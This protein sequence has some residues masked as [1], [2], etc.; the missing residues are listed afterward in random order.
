MAQ[1]GGGGFIF[2]DQVIRFSL[3]SAPVHATLV[4]GSGL[5]LNDH[6]TVCVPPF[7]ELFPCLS[8]DSPIRPPRG[9]F[10]CIRSQGYVKMWKGGSSECT[11]STPRKPFS[12]ELSFGRLLWPLCHPKRSRKHIQGT[13][14]VAHPRQPPR[15]AFLPQMSK[16][17]MITGKL[18]G[19]SKLGGLKAYFGWCLHATLVHPLIWL[20]WRTV[21][22]CFLADLMWIWRQ[23]HGLLL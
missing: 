1:G 17:F 14:I 3:S 4:V 11:P 21:T 9:F 10:W 7:A 16:G 6:V 12:I 15:I 19:G 8:T 23:P 2:N 13:V 20:T 18:L 5:I 22:L